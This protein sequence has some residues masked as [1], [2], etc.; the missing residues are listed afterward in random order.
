[1]RTILDVC[2]GAIAQ[3]QLSHNV[4]RLIPR[5]LNFVDVPDRLLGDLNLPLHLVFEVLHL[6]AQP[7][8]L[9]LRG[10]QLI[11]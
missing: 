1:M 6:P 11:A 4:Q 2:S 10:G 9:D 5:L 8:L 3:Q 7:L